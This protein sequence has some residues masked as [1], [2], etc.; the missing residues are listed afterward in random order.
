MFGG[1]GTQ[2]NSQSPFGATTTSSFGA[3]TPS[4]GQSTGAFGATSSFGQPAQ[5]GAFGQPSTGAF[6]APT[7]SG[8]GAPATSGFGTTGGFGIPQGTSG[9]GASTFG[10]STFGQST[11]AAPAFGS[12]TS[13]GMFG[14]QPTA[15]SFGAPSS[16]GLFGSNT[17]PGTSLFG[18]PTPSASTASPFGFGQPAA[19]PQAAA[20]FGFGATPAN[21]AF[22]MS[23]TGTG[24]PQYKA[25]PDPDTANTGAPGSL[26]SITAMPQY[27]TKSFEELRWEDIQAKK[28]GGGGA[29]TAF[30]PTQPAPT[31]AFGTTNTFTSAPT[32]GAAPTSGGGLFGASTPSPFGAPAPTTTAPTSSFSFN[33]PSTGLGGASLFGS[34]QPTAPQ[35]APTFGGSTFGQQPA[36]PSASP[37]GTAGTG[38][39]LFGGGSTFGQNTAPA[40]S[41]FGQSA[42]SNNNFG[43]GAAPTNNSNTSAPFGTTNAN[44]PSFSF[45]SNPAASTAPNNA[46][47]FG[48]NSSTAGPSNSLFGAAPT[49]TSNMFGQ[50]T[51]PAPQSNLFGSTNP[52]PSLSLG[53]FGTSAPPSAAGGFNF[54]ITSPANSTNLAAPSPIGGGFSFNNTN[55]GTPNFSSLGTTAVS[56][57]GKQAT[58]T[59]SPYGLAPSSLL[60]V[61]ITNTGNAASPS[62][63]PTSAKTKPQSSFSAAFV[64]RS[65]AK[66]KPRGYSTP[67]SKSPLEIPTPSPNEILVPRSS[68]KKLVIDNSVQEFQSASESAGHRTGSAERGQI[69]S[70]ATPLHSYGQQGAPQPSPLHARSPFTSSK[71]NT[72]NVNAPRL[73]KADYFTTPSISELERMSDEELKSVRDFTVG[74]RDVGQV[75]FLGRVDVRNLNLDEIVHLEPKSV[76]IYPENSSVP[77]AAEGEGLNR[78]AVVTLFQVWPLDVKTR[79]LKKDKESLDKYE[80]KVKKTTEASGARLVVYDKTT[81]E[82]VFQVQHF[83][84]Y[85]IAD[86]SDED[87][88]DETP[89]SVQSPPVTG[90]TKKRYPK[91]PT[92]RR[93]LHIEDSE[94]ESEMDGEVDEDRRGDFRTSSPEALAEDDSLEDDADESTNALDSS[95]L[96]GDF[97][98][99]QNELEVSE[100]HDGDDDAV[101]DDSRAIEEDLVEPIEPLRLPSRLGLDTAKMQTMKSFFLDREDESE[102][103]VEKPFAGHFEMEKFMSPVHKIPTF[104]ETDERMTTSFEA[105]E[106]KP[107]LLPWTSSTAKL[108]SFAAEA[109]RHHLQDFEVL[110]RELREQKVPPVPVEH[111]ISFKRQHCL[112]DAGLF[113]GRSFRVGWGPNGL[114]F[115]S[116]NP[117]GRKVNQLG[118]A[119]QISVEKIFVTPEASSADALSIQ[120]LPLLETHFSSSSVQFSEGGIPSFSLKN[121][122]LN[123][124]ATVER[125]SSLVSTGDTDSGS[126][127]HE[128]SEDMEHIRQIFLLV[129]ALWG[130]EKSADKLFRGTSKYMTDNPFYPE[131]VAR[132][133]SLT[134]W[135]KDAVSRDIATDVSLSSESIAK[136]FH[137]LSGK[138]ISEASLEASGSR[139]FRLATLVSQAYSETSMRSDLKEQ[140]KIWRE[141]GTLE[142]LS[143]GHANV[144]HLLGGDVDRVA[145]PLDWKRAFGLYFWYGNPVNSSLFDVAK[146]YDKATEENKCCPPLPNY[147]EGFTRAFETETKISTSED[148]SVHL[149]QGINRCWIKT[150]DESS[151]RNRWERVRPSDIAHLQKNNFISVGAVEHD[152]AYHLIK[153]HADRTYPVWKALSPSAYS[154]FALDYKL[155]WHLLSVFQSLNSLMSPIVSIYLQYAAQLEYLGLWQWSV[156]VLLHLPRENFERDRM[157]KELLVRHVLELGDVAERDI[158]EDVTSDSAITKEAFLIHKLRIPRSWLE[159]AKGW[160]AAYRGED[161]AYCKHLLDAQAF[162]QYESV[163]AVVLRSLAPELILQGKP[164]RVFD[165][166]ARL[167]PHSDNLKAWELGGLVYFEY[168][169]IVRGVRDYVTNREY[170]GTL[171]EQAQQ[172]CRR[173]IATC[174]RI[175]L[176]SDSISKGVGA[177]SEESR[178]QRVCLAR[179]SGHLTELLQNVRQ[180]DAEDRALSKDAMD[181]GS[182]ETATSR[183]IPELLLSVPLTEDARLQQIHEFA[184]LFLNSQMQAVCTY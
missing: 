184:S 71:R 129:N 37:F 163:L 110:R 171:T 151:G 29:P 75:Q 142:F 165:I 173:I 141:N 70:P 183:D 79:A 34:T 157:I 103:H 130:Q 76:E 58:L 33:A 52:A 26:V 182:V 116:G 91:T 87:E 23:T 25:S 168:F 108:E 73:T 93:A 181:D 167:E 126:T 147:A 8:F 59:S 155:S 170:E 3:P 174:K 19:A 123:L 162:D 180:L 140:I 11:T 131:S 152:A 172:L 92:N 96:R 57:P 27:Q 137:M 97:Y 120:Y 56:T 124:T 161:F 9:F 47:N 43:F 118:P 128:K 12:S 24:N 102:A 125:L 68:I 149:W 136:V 7:T 66:M 40:A 109:H 44:P 4:F 67:G 36:Q 48:G 2:T 144:Y 46:F 69:P 153:M 143:E 20:P 55:T 86:E 94:S 117:V 88:S 178:K 31:N 81:G 28:S 51:A 150:L 138:Q 32:F 122:D 158:A 5:T 50:N 134:T 53:G 30:A 115:H 74:R 95:A 13:P 176:Y 49:N 6:G 100:Q 104:E 61:Q 107:A 105:D 62:I 14:Q 41:P 154:P 21:N 35:T 114:L 42:P 121:A 127:S 10:G 54:N 106:P 83:S 119:S 39:S 111:S 38:T 101:F 84:K 148:G 145:R 64:P 164:D 156:Y 1:F 113:M 78:P 72:L 112:A 45:A 132:R 89:K 99:H 90:E 15:S 146:S 82:W 77:K 80:R 139:D 16:G 177:E 60:P 179:I 166:L 135:L 17:S 160:L 169:V 63:T 18:Q 98:D 175:S 22:G 65:A 133:Y 159:E 85:G